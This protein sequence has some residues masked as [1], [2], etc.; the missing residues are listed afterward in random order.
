MSTN[1]AIRAARAFAAAQ[2]AYDNRAEPEPDEDELAE[3]DAIEQA[4]GEL[5]LNAWAILCNLEMVIGATDCE[6]ITDALLNDVNRYP[7][8]NTDLTELPE[9]KLLVLALQTSPSGRELLDRLRKM[10]QSDIAKRAAELLE[11]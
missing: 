9:S 5:H 6:P 8:G 10:V 3:D 1:Q 11:L 2:Y 7:N 4:E